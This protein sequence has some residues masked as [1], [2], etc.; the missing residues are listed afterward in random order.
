MPAQE[1]LLGA[2]GAGQWLPALRNGSQLGAMPTNIQAR[3]DMLYNSLATSWRVDNASSLFDHSG[4]T[5]TSYVVAGY[6]SQTGSCNTTQVNARGANPV[7]LSMTQA[8]AEKAGAG[9]T[10]PNRRAALISD[11]MATGDNS[12]VATYT[13]AQ[14]LIDKKFIPKNPGALQNNGAGTGK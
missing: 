5:A 7:T 4:T 9:I 14:K 8:A 1:G 13:A 2:V 11:L 10:D 3:Y 6:P 12:F